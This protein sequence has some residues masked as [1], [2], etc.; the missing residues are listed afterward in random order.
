MDAHPS[1]S[2]STACMQEAAMLRAVRHTNIVN[3]MGVAVSGL[4]FG[5]NCLMLSHSNGAHKCFLIC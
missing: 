4:C 2:M 3:F 5:M 1:L